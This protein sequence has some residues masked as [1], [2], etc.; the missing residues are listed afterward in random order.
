VKKKL[1][2]IIL[3]HFILSACVQKREVEPDY[4]NQARSLFRNTNWEK[5]TTLNISMVEFFF[6][7]EFASENKFSPFIEFEHLKPYKLIV[8]NEGKK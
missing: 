8:K 4:T 1:L 5:A 6:Q 3:V 7:I 2:I